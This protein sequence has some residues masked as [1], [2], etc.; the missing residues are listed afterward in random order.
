MRITTEPGNF[1]GRGDE[2]RSLKEVTQVLA[3]HKIL[4]P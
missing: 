2:R 4:V 3:K 1:A